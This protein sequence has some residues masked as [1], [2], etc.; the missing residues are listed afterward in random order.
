MKSARKIVARIPIRSE[1][2]G[3]SS[4]VTAAASARGMS[5]SPDS[6]A[7]APLTSCSHWASSNSPADIEKLA[8]RAA[9]TPAE[10][11]R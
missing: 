3:A 11:M 5:C 6:N 8:M 2:T 7:L 1:A 9:R 4:E 10:K